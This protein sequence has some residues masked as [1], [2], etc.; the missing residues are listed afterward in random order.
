MKNADTCALRSCIYK[1]VVGHRRFSPKKHSFKYNVFLLAID[2]DELPR[3]KKLGPW[4]KSNKFAPLNFKC[5]DYLAHK[6]EVT[7]QHVWEKIQSL[8]ATKRPERV[9]FVGQLRCFGLY[10]SPI[11]MYY[12]FDENDRLTYLLAEVSNTPWNQR[13]YY[14]VPITKGKMISD[15]TFHVSPFMDLNMKYQWVIKTPSETLNLHIQNIHS[16]SGDKLFDASL[17][18]NKIPFTNLN[19]FTCI[20]STPIMTLKTLIGIYWQ[21]LK[22]FIKKVPYIAPP[23]V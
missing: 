3:L 8:G 1:G 2:L 15:K 5:R 16:D 10:F 18:M 23:S 13:Y 7:K 9:L 19:L 6:T 22:L 4:F 21:A 20:L 14:L 11:N 17:M 12:C